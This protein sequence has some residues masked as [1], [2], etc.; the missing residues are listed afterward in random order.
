MVN[1]NGILTP[2]LVEN[3]NGAKLYK[4]INPNLIPN[5]LNMVTDSNSVWYKQSS[6]IIENNMAVYQDCSSLIWRSIDVNPKIPYTEFRDKVITF[7]FDGRAD[8]NKESTGSLSSIVYEVCFTSNNTTASRHN[9]YK[10]TNTSALTP[11]WQR[12]ST[13]FAISDSLFVSGSGTP[14]Y[15]SSYLSFRLHRYNLKGCQI[16]NIKVEYGDSATPWCPS[17]KDTG[18]ATPSGQ[19]ITSDNFYEI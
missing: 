10:T 3:S 17:E 5:S 19:I 14:D 13:T 12:Y 9:K 1:K 4:K 7:S 16:K 18:I 15:T 2:S 6:I 11:T 8:E